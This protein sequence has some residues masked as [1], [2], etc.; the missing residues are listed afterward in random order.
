MNFT[1]V[2]LLLGLLAD[3]LGRIVRRQSLYAAGLW[4]MVSKA[5]IK[6]DGGGMAPKRMN[7]PEAHHSTC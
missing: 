3:L 2:L 1:A 5:T 4:M 6:T 7:C